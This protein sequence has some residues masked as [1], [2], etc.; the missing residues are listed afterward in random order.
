VHT[1]WLAKK[2]RL[3]ARVPGFSASEVTSRREGL[4][5]SKSASTFYEFPPASLSL[6][7]S[8]PFAD[9]MRGGGV[10]GGGCLR[11]EIIGGKKQYNGNA[12]EDSQL[13]VT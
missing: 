3:E 5:G 6:L 9:N 13:S 2:K 7:L 1:P 4:V 8:F 11:N 10:L 12:K